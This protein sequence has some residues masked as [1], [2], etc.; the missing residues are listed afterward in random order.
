MSS[1]TRA[2]D[3]D[4]L[5]HQYGDRMAL[6]DV[7]FSVDAGSIFALLGPN[8]GGKTTLF[9]LVTSTLPTTAG[10]IK[11]FGRDIAKDPRHARRLMGVVFQ[12]P[13][14]DERLTVLENLR[15]HGHLY[16]MRGRSLSSRMTDVLELVGLDDRPNDLVSALSGGLQR[17]VEIAKA[18]LPEPKVLVLDEPSTGL[19]PGARREIWDHLERLRRTLGTTVVLTT[20]LMDEAAKSDCVAVLHEGHLVALGPPRDLVAEIGGDVILVAAQ[21]PEDLTQKIRSRFQQPVDIV[22]GQIR[23]ER[24]KGHQFIPELV[25]AFPGQIESVSFGRPTLEDVFL[26]HT[27]QRW[28]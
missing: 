7:A 23:I 6:S 8:G 21:D 22:D 12:S 2:L 27:G 14:L 20:H 13:A 1:E 15:T 19:D 5:S 28:H 26:H 16:G 9:R 18:L 11:V 17:R 24:M 3:V 25:E 4:A 10:H